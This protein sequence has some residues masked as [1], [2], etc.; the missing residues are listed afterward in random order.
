MSAAYKKPDPE[1]RALDWADERGREPAHDA[2]EPT[3]AD[4]SVRH[5]CWNPSG[6]SR[7][8]SIPKEPKRKAQ[9]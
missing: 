6:V 4:G 3:Y 9:D 5:E 2:W 7:K 8:K 1:R